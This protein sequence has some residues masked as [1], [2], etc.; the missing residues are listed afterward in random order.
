MGIGGN[1]GCHIQLVEITD[2]LLFLQVLD[3]TGIGGE[4]IQ[5]LHI[6]IIRLLVQTMV[7]DGDDVLIH[8]LHGSTLPAEGNICQVV[9]IEV[10]HIRQQHVLE[11]YMVKPLIID[12]L[13]KLLA[14]S[15][16]CR[17]PDFLRRELSYQ[18]L[19]HQ[20]TGIGKL[21]QMRFGKI[22]GYNLLH[23][24]VSM[25]L[26]HDGGICQIHIADQPFISIGSLLLQSLISLL[27]HQQE[28]QRQLL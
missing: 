13:P 28:G 22:P 8:L 27:T 18:H 20:G 10:V 14:V 12:F 11:L 2:A 5:I 25:L 21:R 24:G 9:Q 19:H 23:Q 4:K 17:L 1:L 6:R 26:L 15:F 3:G 7:V 16:S